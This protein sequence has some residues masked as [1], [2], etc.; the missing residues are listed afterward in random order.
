MVKYAHNM[1]NKNSY[2]LIAIKYYKTDLHLTIGICYL[3]G[4]KNM[5]M[6]QLKIPAGVF[7]DP[8]VSHLSRCIVSITV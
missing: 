3:C 6:H 2:F 7:D 4:T 8:Y 5:Q 1:N